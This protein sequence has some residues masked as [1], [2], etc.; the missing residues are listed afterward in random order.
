MREFVSMR[1]V[2]VSQLAEIGVFCKTLRCDQVSLTEYIKANGCNELMMYTY[3]YEYVYRNT[4]SIFH[5]QSINNSLL[6]NNSESWGFFVIKCS[7]STIMSY[8]QIMI[9][10]RNKAIIF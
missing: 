2:R 5:Y 7:S 10:E 1:E 4:N 9:L 6:F 8:L 3:E